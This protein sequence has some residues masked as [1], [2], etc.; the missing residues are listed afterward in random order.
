M[1]NETSLMLQSLYFKSGKN[2]ESLQQLPEGVRSAGESG[3]Q[4]DIIF[5]YLRNHSHLA[6]H[7]HPRTVG[8]QL[9]DQVART[10]SK[11]TN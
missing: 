2:Q 1:R 6:E 11:H 3:H 9:K 5:F 8:D 10:I 4:G 7:I